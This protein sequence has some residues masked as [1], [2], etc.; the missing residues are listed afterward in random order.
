MDTPDDVAAQLALIERALTLPFPEAESGEGHWWSGPGHHVLTLHRTRD[1]W[2]P[3]GP[4][5][6]EQ[7]DREIEAVH[8]ALTGALRARWGPAVDVDLAPYLGLDGPD[9]HEQADREIEAVHAALTGAL[10]A[11]WGPAVDVDLAPYLG[12]DWDLQP[13]GHVPEPIAHLCNQ[14]GSMELWQPPDTDRWLGVAVGQADTEFPLELLAAT[15]GP[16]SLPERR[17]AADWPPR[18]W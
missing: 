18:E 16:A 13:P 3:D 6:H 1:F 15:G 10:R 17:T 7:A 4:D 8:A 12:L 11:R 5:D 9:D 2:E 14:A